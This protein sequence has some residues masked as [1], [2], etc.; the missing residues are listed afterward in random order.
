MFRDISIFTLLKLIQWTW[1]WL[2][3]VV[4]LLKKYK[5]FP[6]FYITLR[7]TKRCINECQ[8]LLINFQTFLSHW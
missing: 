6:L 2:K 1:A 4:A 8:L 3:I 5:K 7:F